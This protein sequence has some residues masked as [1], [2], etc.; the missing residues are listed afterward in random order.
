MKLFHHVRL[1]DSAYGTP[2]ILMDWQDPQ[3]AWSIVEPRW[4]GNAANLSCF[5]PAPGGIEVVRAVFEYSPAFDRYLYEWKMPLHLSEG[6]SEAKYHNG[7]VI[8][9]PDETRESDG[10][11]LIGRE[12]GRVWDTPGVVES[13]VAL[14]EFHDYCAGEDLAIL[15]S[16]WPDVDVKL[17]LAM[18]DDA[19]RYFKVAV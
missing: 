15:I 17:P 13:T 10:C 3:A 9:K 14:D 12:F 1:G 4:L 18:V 19:R 2:A 16:W 11:P 5:P 8:I 7:N 6:R